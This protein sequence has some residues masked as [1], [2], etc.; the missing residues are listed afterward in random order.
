MK[1]E[2]VDEEF[3]SASTCLILATIQKIQFFFYLVN[4]KLFGKIKDVSEGKINVGL[5]D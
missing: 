2:D 5:L 4:E 3:L 1:S